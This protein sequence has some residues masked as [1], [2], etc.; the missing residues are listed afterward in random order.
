MTSTRGTVVTCM[1]QSE[2]TKSLLPMSHYRCLSPG[3]VLQRVWQRRPADSCQ[4]LAPGQAIEGPSHLLYL[5]R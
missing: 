5:L 3:G 1:D 2:V 4:P